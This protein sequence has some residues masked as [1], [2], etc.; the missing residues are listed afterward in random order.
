MGQFFA[1]YEPFIRRTLRYRMSQD[2][3]ILRKRLSRALHR[4]AIELKLEDEGDG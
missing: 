1:Q 3:L 4:V 2:A